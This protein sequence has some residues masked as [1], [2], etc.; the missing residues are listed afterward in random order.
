[1]TLSAAELYQRGIDHGNAG[2]NAAARRALA[3]ARARTTDPDLQAR[4][5]GTLSYIA[6][7]TGDPDGAEQLCRDALA[8]DGVSA[9]TAA[10]LAGQLGVLAVHR[11]AYDSAIQWL[12]R[13]IADLGDDPA[14]RGSMLMNRSIAHMQTGQVGRARSDL[15]QA[16][17]DFRLTGGPVDI[18]MARHNL[19]FVLLVEGDLIPALAEMVDARE[20]IAGT[21]PVNLAI[22]DVDRAQVLRDAGLVTEAEHVLAEAA[23]IF[24]A[25]RMRQARGEAEY[26]LARSL[27]LHDPARAAKVAG[28]AARRFR[29]L[30]SAS[31]AAR[32]EGVRVRAEFGRDLEPAT[33]GRPRLPSAEAVEAVAAELD[34]LGFASDAAAVRLTRELWAAQHGETG[35]APTGPAA[36]AAGLRLPRGAPLPVRLLAHQVRAARAAAEGRDAEVRRQAVR[37]L[38]A[39]SSWQDAFGSLDLQTSLAVH[40]TGL[41]TAGLAAALRSGRPATVFEWSERARHLSQRVVPLRPPPDPELAEDLAE[42]RALRTEDPAWLSSPQAVALQERARHRQWVSTGRAGLAERVSLAELQGSLDP[43]T[44]LISYLFD[45]HDLGCLVVTADRARLTDAPPW[46]RLRSVLDGLRA[47]LD[48]AASIRSGPLAAVVARALN[49]RLADLA[50]LLTEAPLAAVG[51]RRVV[52]TAPGELAGLP[53]PMLPGMRGRPLTLAPSATTW[54][55]DRGRAAGPGAGFAAGPGIARAVEEVTAAASAWPAATT[56]L[57]GGATVEAVTGLASRVGVLHLAAHGR[58]A[59]DNPLFS[60]LELA[61]GTLFGYDIDRMPQVPDIVVLSAC[62]LGRSTVRWGEEAIGMTRAWLHAGT[63]CVVAAPVV[64]A[65]DLA[66]ELLGAMHAELAA[67]RPAAEALALA[68][69]RTGINAPF[70]CNGSGF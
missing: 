65:D 15:R 58:H 54:V 39:L 56:L 68:G 46:R 64:V 12:D 6:A 25:H 45:G 9:A 10:I 42:L 55:R 8:A 40:G 4:I 20:L 61:D 41:I 47:D 14:H 44:A 51:D 27:L 21:S 1:M 69:E 70:Q 53:W 13:A 18:A 19:G 49:G 3:T 26:N 60:G 7:R 11:G 16:I 5:A 62:E 34:R 50:H 38:D 52:L 31:W 63:A 17:E 22:S 37:G 23:Q 24:G 33:A 29:S 30:G 57:D 48:M 28:A 67:G 35:P 36:P 43:D 59:V 2:R 32:A 66:C